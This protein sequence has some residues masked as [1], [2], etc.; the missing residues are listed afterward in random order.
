M[1]RASI[2]VVFAGCLLAVC[3]L[4]CN[5]LSNHY[6]TCKLCKSTRE[7][8][9]TSL[10]G[11]FLVTS[12]HTNILY[13]SP[14]FA[15]C[16]HQWEAGVTFGVGE[17]IPNGKVVLVRLGDS[18]GAFILTNQFLNPERMEFTWY[19]RT[20]GKSVFDAQDPAVSK[21]MGSG[22]KIRFGPFNVSWS[23]AGNGQG[24]IYYRHFAGDAIASNSVRICVTDLGTVNTI[25]A[26]DPKWIY[27]GSP[28]DTGS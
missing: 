2:N 15:S 9:S 6:E 12:L 22:S 3:L 23:G 17:S 20:D 7:I 1:R 16:Q 27:K 21:G 10:I 13:K 5:R 8:T 14:S 25:N 11:P 19:L 28:A 24:W 18:Y 26:S 4:G